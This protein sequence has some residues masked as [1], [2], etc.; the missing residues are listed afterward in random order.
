MSLV[1]VL[2]VLAIVGIV[3]LGMTTMINNMSKSVSSLKK[4]GE[5]ITAYVSVLSLLQ[6]KESCAAGLGFPNVGTWDSAINISEIKLGT[7]TV[8]KVNT[9]IN[10]LITRNLKLEK[11]DGPFNLA[12]NTTPA[13]AAPTIV[14]RKRFLSKLTVTIEKAAA[15]NDSNVGGNA[16]KNKLFY[17]TSTV[18][19]T[20]K[21]IECYGGDATNF[22][23]DL[24]EQQIGGEYNAGEYPSCLIRRLSIAGTFAERNAGLPALPD[25]TNTNFFLQGNMKVKG[26]VNSASS[27]TLTTLGLF[28]G[29]TTGQYSGDSLT[30]Q[31]DGQA[32][33]TVSG[34][35]DLMPGGTTEVAT[36]S[37]VILDKKTSNAYPWFMAYKGY[38]EQPGVDPES[39]IFGKY[40]VP[41]VNGYFMTI[42]K[43]G[44]VGIGTSKPEPAMNLQVN[45]AGQAAL[46]LKGDGEVGSGAT[47][48]AVYLG[49]SSGSATNN[50]WVLGHKKIPDGNFIIG[51]WINQTMPSLFSISPDGAV[52]IS[53]TAST[54]LVVNK[55]VSV[56]GVLTALSDERLKKEFQPISN[57]LQRLLKI[58]GYSYIWQ[59]EQKGKDRI[60][61]VK[62][63]EV[64]KSF[65]ELVTQ[66]NNGIKSV[67]YMN[68]VAPIID[69]NLT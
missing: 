56:G 50:S 33:V 7:D 59:D 53:A 42:T 69:P 6:T 28:E 2:I 34:D 20:G 39:L 47:Y 24:C 21:L 14:Y 58:Q 9:E 17:F 40:Q 61:G 13:P 32:R 57:S 63:Q 65:P 26:N 3:S 52:T 8:L 35:G 18:D 11:V 60:L 36:Y 43:N 44:Q 16:I 31:S 48:S 30:V 37:S 22:L 4:S 27:P 62:A 54:A 12:F 51:K 45:S 5:A 15:A 68:F 66:N 25:A 19:D 41:G 46:Y 64:E 55:D 29:H 38:G 67:A 1:E 49:V 23:Q 10:G